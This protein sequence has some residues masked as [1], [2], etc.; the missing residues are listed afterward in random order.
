LNTIF[1]LQGKRTDIPDLKYFERAFNKYS[2]ISLKEVKNSDSSLIGYFFLL[3]DPKKYK[4]DALIPELFKQS[5]EIMPEYSPLYSY[6]IYTNYELI[7]HYNEYSFPIRLDSNKL[8]NSEFEERK[9]GVYDELWYRHAKD[10][11]VIIARKNNSFLEA[12][13]LFAYLFSTFLFLLALYWL[14]SV[15]IRS[16][17]RWEKIKSNWQFSI[18]MQIH[19]T[20]ILISLLSFIVIGAATIL[21]FINRYDRNNQER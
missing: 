11:I 16:R 14:A 13:T 2:Y 21:F 19:S 6:A 3:A 12:I 17:F 1:R 4:N 15:I 20:I 18:R 8:F 10:K 7:N 9:N 5:K